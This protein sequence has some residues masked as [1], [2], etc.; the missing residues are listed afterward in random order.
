MQYWKAFQ[1]LFQFKFFQIACVYMKDFKKFNMK[2]ARI[3][4]TEIE[5]ITWGYSSVIVFA[6]SL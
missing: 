3:M 1:L 2:M 5:N 4:E 6:F